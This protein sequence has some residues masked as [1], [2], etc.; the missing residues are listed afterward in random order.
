MTLF[1][2][3]KPVK[4]VSRLRSVKNVTKDALIEEII[5]RSW[6]LSHAVDHQRIRLGQRKRG[7]LENLVTF[8][9]RKDGVT[10]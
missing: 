6:T 8:W 1:E 7:E 2:K 4:K 10:S 9:R 3:E 5:S